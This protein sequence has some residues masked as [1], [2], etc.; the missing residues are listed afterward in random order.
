MTGSNINTVIYQTDGNELIEEI[1]SK[2]KRANIACE[3]VTSTVWRHG[4]PRTEHV[5]SVSKADALSAKRALRELPLQEPEQA[6]SRE[7]R[8]VIIFALA[9]ISIVTVVRVVSL[10]RG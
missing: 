6:L 3:V 5:F 1:I 2:L 4:L 9:V 10:I 7:R 8:L